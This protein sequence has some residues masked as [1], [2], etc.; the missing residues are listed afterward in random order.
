MMERFRTYQIAR[1]A[2][3]LVNLATVAFV[4]WILVSTTDLVCLN[5]DARDL[6]E[7]LK[8]VPFRPRD[9]LI[10]SIGLYLALIASVVFRE[11]LNDRLDPVPILFLSLLDLALCVGILGTLDFGVKYILL[12]PVANG[13]AYLPDKIWKTAFT[14]LVVGC[15]V[16]L[17]YE[18]ISAGIP[19]FSMNDY[20]LY[21]PA[22][23]RAYLMGARN[24]LFSVGE[25]LFIA[26][27]VLELQNVL[28]ESRRIRL[29]NRALTE[30]HDKLAV[31]HAQL[32]K[33]SERT[34]ELA[35]TKE[36]N[37]LA[38]EIHDT[39]GH[40][41][42]GIS[43][44]LQAT[45]EL[46]RS[47][48][49]TVGDQ[50]GRLDELSRQGLLDIRRS[51]KELRP[52]ML[53][54]RNLSA[55]LSA[56]AREINSC[57]TRRIELIVEG[58]ADGLNPSLEETVYRIVQESITNAV[59]HGNAGTVRIA[60]AVGDDSLRIDIS[61]D[62]SGCS[63]V[64]EGFGLQYMRERVIAHDGFMEIESTPGKGFSLSVF[65]PR[66]GAKRHD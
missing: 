37:R 9:A 40:C 8:A 38:R 24:V 22:V 3:I 43:L 54:R 64:S 58:E 5:D 18:I 50:L 1:Y 34:E 61:D 42:T 46:A 36:R 39:V 14:A 29:L 63:A 15:Y 65:I 66:S 17:D 57:S 31:A 53:E 11:A 2:L 35:K 21:H 10:G 20:I 26:F 48:P 56:L 32:Q 6:L 59:R 62:G 60:L 12:V 23:S 51:L 28:E 45:R 25:V 13:V 30:S 4:A 52:D 19:V 7:R 16:L 55:A 41:L 47:D 27:L 44:G 33:Y 49:S